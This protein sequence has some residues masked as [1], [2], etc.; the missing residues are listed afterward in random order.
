V[1]FIGHLSQFSDEWKSM[2]D[3]NEFGTTEAIALEK[4]GGRRKQI[5][6]SMAFAPT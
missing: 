2:C 5:A 6:I 3:W 1:N 4:A